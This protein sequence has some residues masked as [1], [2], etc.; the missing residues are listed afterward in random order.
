MTILFRF[1]LISVGII[2]LASAWWA[3]TLYDWS[4]AV[5]RRWGLEKAA[6]MRERLKPWMVPVA[7]F[8]LAVMG[9]A[10]LGY[11]LVAAQ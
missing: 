3:E 5:S 10:F 2:L 9:F 7:R 8:V 1:Y 4:T 11:A 6:D